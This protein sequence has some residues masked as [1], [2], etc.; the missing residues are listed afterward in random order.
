M[1]SEL[2]K[3]II[4]Y[5]SKAPVLIISIFFMQ[6]QGELI[7]RIIKGVNQSFKFY[8]TLSIGIGCSAICL[9]LL[10]LNSMLSS[11]FSLENLESGVLAAT[12]I[13]YA[14]IAI[15]ALIVLTIREAKTLKGKID[16]GK[17]T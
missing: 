5:L 6:M 16:D 10:N 15:I 8:T 3:T 12:F 11:T 4:E 14:I 2:G 1:D 17:E 7:L 13:S 9:V